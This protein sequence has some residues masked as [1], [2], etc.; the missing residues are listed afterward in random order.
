MVSSAPCVSF[1][2]AMKPHHWFFRGQIESS[3]VPATRHD[4]PSCAV[5][6]MNFSNTLR[7]D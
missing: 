1:S 7:T 2:I 5:R 4:S 3:A 6:P